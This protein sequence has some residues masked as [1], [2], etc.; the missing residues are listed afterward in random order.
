MCDRVRCEEDA[1]LDEWLDL[2]I[3]TWEARVP[4]SADGVRLPW[5][6]WPTTLCGDLTWAVVLGPVPTTAPM[7]GCAEFIEAEWVTDAVELVSAS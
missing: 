1:H 2:W 3:D 5:W 4:R 7:Q 6:R